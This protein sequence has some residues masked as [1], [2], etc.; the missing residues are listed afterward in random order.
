MSTVELDGYE[1][2]FKIP[3]SLALSELVLDEVNIKVLLISHG[4]F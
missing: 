1:W 4:I 3:I 2:Q